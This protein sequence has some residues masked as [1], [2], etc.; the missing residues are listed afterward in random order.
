MGY[1][2]YRED[3]E[4]SVDTWEV[5]DQQRAESPGNFV[6]PPGVSEISW[7]KLY[8]AQDK[9]ADG[10]V[11]LATA[12]KLDGMGIN[13][14]FKPFYLPGPFGGTSNTGASEQSLHLHEDIVFNTAIPVVPGQT[15]V[16]SGQMFGEDAVD[17]QFGIV[18]GYNCP[19]N[20][21]SGP[22]IR[23]TAMREADLADATEAL[24]ALT[25]DLEGGTSNAIIPTGVGRIAGIAYGAG[26]DVALDTRIAHHFELDGDG[27]PLA[28]KPQR[29]CGVFGTNRLDTEGGE[30]WYKK[31]ELLWVDWPVVQGRAVT[32]RAGMV[33]DD[34]GA[35]TAFQCLLMV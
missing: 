4:A 18:L 34:Y 24:V 32:M 20:P 11:R 7:V 28:I 8:A 17:V 19:R 3:T 14:A 21:G 22:I 15:I 31:P 27:L 10:I 33:E 29:W 16:A 26:V 23:A 5:L 25:G 1:V 30:T 35:G 9:G 6:V 12:F 13:S 2:D